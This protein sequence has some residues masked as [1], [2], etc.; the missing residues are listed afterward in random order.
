MHR[1]KAIKDWTLGFGIGY[2]DT[3]TGI[4]YLSPVPIV[5]GTCMIEGKLI[6]ADK[7]RS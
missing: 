6:V 4:V 3:K 5:K 1:I 7:G 2:L